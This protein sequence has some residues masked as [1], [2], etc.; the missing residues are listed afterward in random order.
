MAFWAAD[1]RKTLISM[2]RPLIKEPALIQRWE[3]GNLRKAECISDN[4]YFNPG[5]EGKG[6]SCVTR[7]IE[8]NRTSGRPATSQFS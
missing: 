6:I 8:G 2:S 1:T 5:F 4:L 3:K 7:E